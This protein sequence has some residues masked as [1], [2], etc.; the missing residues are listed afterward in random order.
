MANKAYSST[1]LIEVQ[2]GAKE[3]WCYGIFWHDHLVDTME[4][5]ELQDP[6]GQQEQPRGFVG[7]G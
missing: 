6:S 3:G 4:G 5:N 1:W 2:E 7:F